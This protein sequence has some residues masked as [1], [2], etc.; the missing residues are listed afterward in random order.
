M[1]AYVRWV[2]WY[3]VM[4]IQGRTLGEPGRQCLHPLIKATSP[5]VIR[6][7]RTRGEG[8]FTSLMFFPKTNNH[9]LVMRKT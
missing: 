9:S 1:L 6:G 2:E 7:D 4:K 3:T 8:H 5:G